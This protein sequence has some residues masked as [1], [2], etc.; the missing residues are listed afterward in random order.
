M[1]NGLPMDSLLVIVGSL[2]L[3]IDRPARFVVNCPGGTNSWPFH[4][5]CLCA[6]SEQ[7]CHTCLLPAPLSHKTQI[8]GIDSHASLRRS[9]VT[10]CLVANPYSMSSSRIMNGLLCHTMSDSLLNTL[11]TS[12]KSWQWI[13]YIIILQSLPLW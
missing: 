12:S 7:G 13:I 11:S 4:K 1:D 8:L 10:Y 3:N 2:W 6:D 5:D 9:H